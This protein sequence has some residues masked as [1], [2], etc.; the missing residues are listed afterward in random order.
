M[1]YYL[2]NLPQLPSPVG[3]DRNSFYQPWVDDD[4]VMRLNTK[5]KAAWR[6]QC[7]QGEDF[8][9]R[10]DCS[11]TQNDQEAQPLSTHASF[12]EP[13]SSIP[14]RNRATTQPSFVR[15]MLATACATAI[16]ICA[17]SLGL[18]AAHHT[19]PKNWPTAT[20]SK[21]NLLLSHR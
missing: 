2:Q 17:A 14:L 20:N 4:A 16:L 15:R 5:P 6:E 10:N 13:I 19:S 21:I 1:A 18:W 12:S 7:Y 11:I 9:G 3:E 8:A